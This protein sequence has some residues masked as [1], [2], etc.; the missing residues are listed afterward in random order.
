MSIYWT[1][2]QIVGGLSFEEGL[3]GENLMIR[4]VRDRFLIC[5]ET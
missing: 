3:N 2:A 5:T 4:Y 1:T